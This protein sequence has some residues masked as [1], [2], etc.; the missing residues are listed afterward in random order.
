MD[1]HPLHVAYSDQSREA[2]LN[3]R[4]RQCWLPLPGYTEIV[5]F[6]PNVTCAGI[7]GK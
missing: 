6:I 5:G 7:A 3:Q 4:A 2:G 1:A